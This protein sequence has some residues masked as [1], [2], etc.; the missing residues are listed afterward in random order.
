MRLHVVVR[1]RVQ[2]VGF[3]WFVRETAR[4]L[5]AAGWVRNRTDGTVEVAAE[6]DE[7][8]A[9]QFLDALR[10]GP[11]GALVTSVDDVGSIE[12]PLSRPFGIMR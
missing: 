11:P 1:G 2:G 6:V 8:R 10:D 4:A 3:R 7:G 9:E 12:E 5:G